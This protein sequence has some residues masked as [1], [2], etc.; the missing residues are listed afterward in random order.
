MEDINPSVTNCDDTFIELEIIPEE[1]KVNKPY[2]EH[3]LSEIQEEFDN[4]KVEVPKLTGDEKIQLYPKFFTMEPQTIRKCRFLYYPTFTVLITLI[5]ISVFIWLVATYGFGTSAENPML[6]PSAQSLLDAGGKYGPSIRQGEWWRFI[7]PIFLHAG[8]VHLFLNLVSQFIFCW[9]LEKQYNSIRVAAVYFISG[10]G[11]VVWSAIFIPDLVSVGASSAIFGLF[12]MYMVD[13][14]QNIGR[15]YFPT[16]ILVTSI[17]CLIVSLVIG[18]LPLVD[19]FAHI[20]GLFYGVLS[21]IIIIPT[22]HYQS[23]KKRIAR[24]VCT[25]VFIPILLVTFIGAFILFYFVVDPNGWCDWCL[26]ITD[27]F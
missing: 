22:F 1:L 27:V 16:A 9:I 13:I 17:I 4:S 2:N 19:N 8:F 21:S 24:L 25:I 26:Y 15:I 5:D 11:G 18:L 6:G 23:R 20:G 7:T 10:I 3:S 12:G 14:I